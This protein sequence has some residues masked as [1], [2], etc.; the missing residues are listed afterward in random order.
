MTVIAEQT[1]EIMWQRWSMNMH[2]V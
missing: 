1:A 2:L